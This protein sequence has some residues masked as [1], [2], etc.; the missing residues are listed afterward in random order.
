M[1]ERSIAAT[2]SVARAT[3]CNDLPT[4]AVPV[5]AQFHLEHLWQHSDEDKNGRFELML[6]NIG[7]RSLASFHLTYTALRVVEG[8]P[9]AR[10]A[11]LLRRHGYF[12][13]V[14]PPDGFVLA[15]GAV[16]RF[17]LGGLG[18]APRHRS[19]GILSAYVTFGDGSH[20]PVII[21]DLRK[22]SIEADAMPARSQAKQRSA[23]EVAPYLL[24]PWPKELQ[25]LPADVAPSIVAAASG[26]ARADLAA[27]SRLQ[28]LFRRLFP[29][30]PAVLSLA[31]LPGDR[32]LRFLTDA[33]FTSGQYRLEFGVDEIT[34]VHGDD[35][36]RQYGLTAICQM[37]RGA[38]LDQRLRFPASGHIDDGPQFSW[39]GCHLD[40]AR[41]FYPIAE[42]A[43]LLDI[44]AYLRMNIFHWHLTD[45]EAWRLEIGRFPQLTEV[46]AMRG[47]DAHLL[48]Q[49]GDTCEGSGGSYS[50]ANVRWLIEYAADQ[51]IEIIPE[52]DVPGHCSAAL[53][54]LPALLDPDEPSDAYVSA[55][56]FPNNALNPAVDFTFSFLEA[57][58]DE[59]ATLFPSRY[60]HVGGDEVA[61]NA[62]LASPLALRMMQERGHS[63]TRDLQSFF[64]RKVQSLLAQRGRT[65]VGWN[66]VAAGDGVDARN[67]LLMAWQNPKIGS[68][69]AAAGYDFVMTP[70]QAYYLD[71]A[72]SHDWNEVGASWAGATTPEQT[73]RYDPVDG[74]PEQSRERLRGI[75]A[76]IWSEL[77]ET[78]AHFNHLVFPRLAAVAETAWTPDDAKD[79]DRFRQI[80][81]LCPE[82]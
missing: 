24:T 20:H 52:V 75:Q 57:V 56:G 11:R 14:A 60:V 41:R 77:I 53:A 26:C 33:T 13:E 51:N 54:A 19:E 18:G 66:E 32:T 65:L 21:G 50:A 34:L 59:V 27:M 79:W 23:L 68:D 48:P 16:W 71:I 81:H 40:T 74:L 44:L 8:E 2:E 61:Q 45:D 36:G 1:T 12:H 64:M 6:F 3:S 73:Y 37:L 17:S 49:L 62:W 70:A 10:N 7:D 22:P 5:R 67:A 30:E 82:L 31:A 78:R 69:L 9:L 15:P 63:G 76:C 46:G 43:R 55:Q 72:Q 39:R 35:A 47:P 38:R 42:I 80:M 58:F 28:A 25:V 29:L 4:A